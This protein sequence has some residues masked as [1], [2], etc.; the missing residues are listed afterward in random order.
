V[1]GVSE[2]CPREFEGGGGGGAG[3]SAGSGTG[4]SASAG[5]SKFGPVLRF[6]RELLDCGRDCHT[7]KVKHC[8]SYIKDRTKNGGEWDVPVVLCQSL[9]RYSA[10]PNDGRVQRWQEQDLMF[11]ERT[12]PMVNE[13]DSS[14]QLQG[15]GH[16][17]TKEN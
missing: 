17:R 11:C 5:L 4:R 12:P 1:A 15:M 7:Q 3:L 16:A 13:D 2:E 10:S 6:S 9:I 8:K 14:S